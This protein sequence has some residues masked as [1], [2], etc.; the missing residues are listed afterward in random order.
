M[1][2]SYKKNDNNELFESLEKKDLLNVSTPQNYIPIYSRFFSLSSSNCDQINLNNFFTLKII[3]QKI[4]ENKFQGVITN[5]S[6]E[7]LNKPI[8]FKLSP[9]LDPIKYMTGKYDLN[10]EHLL[11]LPIYDISNN[12]A[13][14]RDINNA[15]YVDSFFTYLTSQ[16][17]HTH[18]FVH[19]VDF[20]GSFLAT[21]ND[22]MVDVC[23]D[24]EYLFESKAFHKNKDVLFYLD[25]TFHSDIFNY[26]TR[27]YKSR[28]TIEDISSSNLQLSDINDLEHLDNLFI[29]TDS[30][31]NQEEPNLL[32]EGKSS[33]KSNTR[34]AGSTC[35]SRSSNTNQSN[36]SD[37]DDE[38]NSE[39]SKES[40]T[41]SDDEVYIKLPQF[42]IQII[43]L[44]CCHKTLDSLIVN[45]ELSDNEWDSIVLQILMMLITYQNMLK[46]THNDLHTCNIMY[47]N[48][49][50][51]YLFYKVN[52]R[53]YKVPT[54]GKIF[55]IIDYGRAIYKFRGNLFCS[56]SFHSE[57]D[58]ATQYNIEPYF[59]E[60][61]PRLEPNFSF[62]L[63][64]LGCSLFDFIVDDFEN[65]GKIKSHILRVMLDWCKDDKGRNVMY[66]NNGTERYPEFKLYKMIARTVHNHI[67]NNVLKD[68]YFDRYVVSRKKINKNQK[69]FNIDDM[70][71]YE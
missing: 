45:N 34:S 40:S 2:F 43:A 36:D 52:G 65:M 58:A 66:K 48:T 67:P 3:T 8:F 17:L 16:I 55:K 68:V 50:K 21:K 19:G 47:I 42:P 24:V 11:N 38:K 5:H 62:D 46:L 33:P 39:Y 12:H 60:K 49:D 15:A 30:N 64:R 63:C 56:D 1:D 6:G 23:E 69:I 61:K 54:F 44:E 70:P 14:V 59:N 13:K 32:Y 4:S 10:N 57:G 28:L 22:L 26:D 41:A 53:H 51:Q 9:L 25:N 71:C 29:A 18:N 35:S 31:N 37:D 20:Y 27:N 7:E